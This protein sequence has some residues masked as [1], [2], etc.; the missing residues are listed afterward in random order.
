MDP[1]KLL[2]YPVISKTTHHTINIKIYSERAK[3]AL[4]KNVFILFEKIIYNFALNLGV[5]VYIRVHPK[6][7]YFVDQVHASKNNIHFSISILLLVLASVKTSQDWSTAHCQFWPWSNPTM[8]SWPWSILTDRSDHGQNF[9]LIISWFL[10][11]R[12]QIDHEDYEN[13]LAVKDRFIPKGPGAKISN[14]SL[15]TES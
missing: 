8:V 5:G 14:K 7:Q 11:I 9:K 13:R 3:L 1:Q 4:Y 6:K 12:Y 2:F 10:I 15:N